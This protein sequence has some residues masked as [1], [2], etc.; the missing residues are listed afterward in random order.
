[1]TVGSTPKL[2]VVTRH[3]PADSTIKCY[4]TLTSENLLF[5]DVRNKWVLR[6]CAIPLLL[7]YALLVPDKPYWCGHLN[8]I[9]R[10][11]RSLPD[12]WIDRACLQ[13]LLGVGLRRAQQILAPCVGRQVG[14]NGLADRE[15]VIAHL[16]R[17]AAGDTACYERQR[18]QKLAERIA[19]LL[20]ERS[21]ALMVAAPTAIV[22]QELAG[23]PEGISIEPGCLTVRF[24]TA[25]QALEKLLALAMAIR[26]DPALFEEMATAPR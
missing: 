1:M 12:P 21:N 13:Q 9:I 11:L 3:R 24:A 25:R 26:N 15:V 19:A 20:Q 10:D 23:L 4:L 8:E 18:R 22:N 5:S 7:W 14:V 2:N 6:R 17:L 16:G